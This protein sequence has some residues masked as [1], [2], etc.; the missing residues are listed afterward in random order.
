MNSSVEND[1]EAWEGEGGAAPPPLSARAIL[2]S[3]TV[4]QVEWAERIKHQVNDEFDRVARS[5]R[6]VADKQSD[7]ARAEILTHSEE[8]VRQPVMNCGTEGAVFAEK[9]KNH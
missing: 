7:V 8:P 4:N 6:S 1:I 5:S 2:L 9:I 3:G